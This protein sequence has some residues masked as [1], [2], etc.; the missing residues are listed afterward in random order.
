[1][2][3]LINRICAAL[4]GYFWLPCPVC[5]KGFGGHEMQLGLVPLIVNGHAMGVCSFNC[6]LKA[7][8]MNKE[9]GEFWPF[10][11]QDPSK[12]PLSDIQG[13]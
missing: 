4:F 1:M 9:N 12:N 7:Q 10:G 3:R 2:I 5:K 13:D 6:S 8:E 11:I